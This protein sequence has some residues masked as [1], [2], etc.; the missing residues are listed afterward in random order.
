VK[1]SKDTVAVVT[2]A[3]RA[4]GIG[5]ALV[6]EL[7]DRGCGQVLGTYRSTEN[8]A[9]LLELAASDARV[10]AHA[11][12]VTDAA[13]VD[14][15]AKFC[16]EQYTKIDLLVNNSGIPSTKARSFMEAT[17][18]QYDQQLQVHAVGPLRLTRALWP[19]LKASG[20]ALILNISSDA[21]TMARMPDGLIH[22]G[23]AKVAQNALSLQ[24][25][26]YLEGEAIVVPI[27]PGWVA[28][29]LAGPGAPILAP[30]S[31]RGLADQI[32]RITAADSGVFIDWRG[33]KLDW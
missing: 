26:S 4:R 31:A 29:D 2:G 12:D 7:L 23:P 14:E 9:A 21:G 11:L 5:L 19:L 28:T 13:S 6:R 20:S 16:A 15:F 3:N 10:K 27:H 33:H 8:S 30:E 17:A 25:A 18:E 22:Y 32:E 1:I 24:M